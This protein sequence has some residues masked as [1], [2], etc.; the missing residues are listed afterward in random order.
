MAGPSDEDNALIS[1]PL[2]DLDDGGLSPEDVLL[3]AIRQS[4]RETVGPAAQT[5]DLS[6]V[7]E[8][9]IDP[10]PASSV[11]HLPM[12]DRAPASPDPAAEPHHRPD[13]AHNPFAAAPSILP[14]ADSGAG[15]G[16]EF[17]L[18]NRSG[19]RNR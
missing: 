14:Q 3:A 6:E 17:P 9:V 7:D 13:H 11:L 12:I 4:R 10:Q 15:M 8:P 19:R 1:E 5:P 2:G 16:F 18:I